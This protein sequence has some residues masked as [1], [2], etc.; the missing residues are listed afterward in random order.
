MEMA[1]A[2]VINKADGENVKAAKRAKAEYQNALH[3]F[4]V[5]P[6]G[7]IPQVKLCSSLH[8][9]GVV[10]IWTMI[11]EHAEKMA[12]NGFLEKNRQEQQLNWFKENLQEL[13]A[14]AFYADDNVQHDLPT[15][16]QKVAN[17]E[18][19]ALNA[20]HLLIEKFF[21]S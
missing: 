18:L 10:E 15:I 16:R 5:D 19:P 7:W 2:V 4:P 13:L 17:G 3:L 14:N 12:L 20:A 6:S 11:Q 21:K 1:H 9:E 8:N